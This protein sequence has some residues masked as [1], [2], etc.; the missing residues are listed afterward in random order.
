MAL[1]AVL[2]IVILLTV[3]VAVLAKT[4]RVETR[5]SFGNDL[6]LKN[7]WA[8]RAALE[9]TLALLIEDD[10]ACDS[11]NDLWYDNDDDCTDIS[12]D[13][14]SFTVQITDEAAK[15]NINTVA[16]GKLM[17]LPDMT[18]DIADA[19]IDWR[20][21]DDTPQQLGTEGGYYANL[22]PGYQIRN[23]P[24]RTIRELLLVKD[25]T[26]ELLYGEDTNFNGKLDYNE[27][28]GSENPPM[29]NGN[30]YLDEGWIAWLTCYA[31]DKNT[32]AQ[33]NQR[34]NINSADESTLMESLGL[35]KSH[36]K[37]I[38]D[39]RNN[40][41]NSIADLINKNSP[42]KPPADADD[43]SDEAR[44]LDIETFRNI[45][46]RITIND[47]D[48]INGRV[49]INTAPREVLMTLLDEKQDVVEAIISHRQNLATGMESIADIL[50]IKAVSVDNFKAIAN[51]ITTRS[52]VFSA[53]CLATAEATAACYRLQVVLDRDQENQ[54]VI[55]WR[56]GANN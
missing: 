44:E 23:A 22:T 13:T 19:I 14:V 8:C 32:D 51:N 53:Q 11:L 52:N 26:P 31:Y 15:L 47:D 29:D 3:M 21:D 49:N 33:G 20:D 34:V 56:E 9:T 55:Y 40:N 27:R 50:D 39:N 35:S 1:V 38:I 42:K 43:N 17:L 6:N 30:D 41:F 12:M 2:W 25:V 16:K 10:R 4:T 48:K 5:L 46:D 7:R 24:F 37:W 54:P 45:A 36:A 18:E 28:D